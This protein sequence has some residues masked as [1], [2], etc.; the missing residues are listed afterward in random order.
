MRAPGEGSEAWQMSA[1][2][3]SGLLLGLL[4]RDNKQSLIYT[5]ASATS[6]SMSMQIRFCDDYSLIGR[7]LKVFKTF[8]RLNHQNWEE[9][10]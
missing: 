2:C 5:L 7:L 4:T 9:C 3:L 1:R 10:H 8:M 6:L